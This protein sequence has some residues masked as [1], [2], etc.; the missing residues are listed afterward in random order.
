MLLRKCNLSISWVLLYAA[1]SY[2]Q[3]MEP[4]S[5][6][7]TR[8]DDVSETMHGVRIAEPYQWLE[9]LNSPETMAWVKAQNDLTQKRLDA[10]PA[11]SLIR[12]RLEQLSAF[13]TFGIPIKRRD[14]IIYAWR[15]PGEQQALIYQQ[16]GLHGRARVLLD[17]NTLSKDGSV[18]VAAE[19][20]GLY[21]SDDGRFLAYPITNGGSDWLTYRIRDTRSNRDL[22]DELKWVKQVGA[23]KLVCW[24]PNRDGFYYVRFAAPVAGREHE[25]TTRDPMVYHHR[26]GTSQDK[27]RLVVSKSGTSDFFL[28]PDISEDGR[29]LIVNYGQSHVR[30][31]VFYVDSKRSAA[32]LLPLMD[33]FDA[34]YWFVGSKA[35]TL[36]FWTEKDAPHGRVIAVD[37]DHPAEFNWKT[38]VPESDLVV[39]QVKFI[40]NRFVVV[41]YS[42][43]RT[44]ILLYQ[45]DGTKAGE[46]QLPTFGRVSDVVHDG[47]S[48]RADDDDMFY[49]FSSFAEPAT[50]FH[51]DFKSKISSVFREPQTPFNSRDFETRQVFT[52]SRDGTRIPI[53][54]FSRTGKQPSADTPVYL[55]GY[56]GFGI[57]SPPEFRLGATLW[58]EMN[59][60]FA[61]A[62]I[63]GG[64]EYGEAWHRQGNRENKQNVFDD[65]TAAAHYLIDQGR[66]KPARLAISG[67]SNGGLLTAAMLTQH[68]ELFG[69]VVIRVGV[70]DMLRFQHFT[71]GRTLFPEFGNPEDPEDFKYLYR[72]S[73][74]HNIH[75]RTAYPATLLMTGS[76]D[77]RV[78]PS[79]S[80]KMAAALQAAQGGSAPI[81]LRVL[82]RSGHGFGKSASAEV[83]SLTDE[84]TF[85][86]E[87]LKMQPAFQ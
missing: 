25:Q 66:T 18:A 51:Y 74:L 72:Y 58:A 24:S 29:Y 12:N 21:L 32:G 23:G 50:V 20:G 86:V 79:H 34:N 3:T 55:T 41:G 42:D 56:G 63:R 62:D 59:G 49:V 80:Y 39:Q 19:F 85:I 40:A 7:P 1:A 11:F 15:K 10:D 60:V 65:F 61:L 27:D 31:A 13:E 78:V 43:V 70:T 33:K 87:A 69:A 52:T 4:I 82:D 26:L 45:S 30:S 14:T 2:G 83:Q 76:L 35:R 77:D 75:E 38:V 8:R 67:A 9:E 64:S 37:L 81:L 53:F 73:P 68:P 28:R 47:V 17:P 16:H 22:T 36:Y 5:Y 57:P 71:I 84:Y 46:I 48:G 54:L 6:P 44:R